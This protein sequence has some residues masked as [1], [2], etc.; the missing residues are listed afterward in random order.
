MAAESASVN[1]TELKYLELC[2]VVID[3]EFSGE[4]IDLDLFI[5][6]IELLK[7]LDPSHSQELK[8]FIMS[9][10]GKA[11][12][13]VPN[14]PESVDAIIKALRNEINPR[15][16]KLISIEMDYLPCKNRQEL[17]F[18]RKLDSLAE[19]YERSLIFEGFSRHLAKAIEKVTEVCE[20]NA[21][22]QVV[23]LTIHFSKFENPRDVIEKFV[24]TT[25]MEAESGR[26]KTR[27]R[28]YRQ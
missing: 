6:S 3:D 8:M 12:V 10:L 27:P 16:S 5:K 18:K 7:R 13:Y 19:A 1:L 24:L 17:Q 11:A 26:H 2:L 22:Y 25:N 15:S 14:E 21:N 9:R 28:N 4:Y 20:K 23:Q